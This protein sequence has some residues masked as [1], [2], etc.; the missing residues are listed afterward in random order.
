[1][2]TPVWSL[3]QEESETRWEVA[4]LYYPRLKEG[5]GKT[6]SI[7]RANLG[8]GSGQIILVRKDQ[9]ESSGQ[10][11]KSHGSNAET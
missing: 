10:T 8:T 1:L 9:Q 7:L 5:T 6:F 11:A 4:L 3:H 2:G